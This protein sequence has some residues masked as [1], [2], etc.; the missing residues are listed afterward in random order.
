MD[1]KTAGLGDKN[2]TISSNAFDD[3]FSMIGLDDDEF[4]K[5]QSERRP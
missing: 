3:P 5:W 4:E 1:A 2:P